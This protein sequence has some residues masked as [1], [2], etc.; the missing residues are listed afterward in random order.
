MRVPPIAEIDSVGV[1]PSSLSFRFGSPTGMDGLLAVSL[2]ALRRHL[3][4]TMP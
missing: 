1:L 4:V 2:G 3:S